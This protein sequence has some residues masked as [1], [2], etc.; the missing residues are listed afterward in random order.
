MLH[1]PYLQQLCKM[2]NKM[3]AKIT[4]IGSNLIN[5]TGVEYLGGC[6]HKILPDMI[7]I[8]SFIGLAAITKS[9]ITIKNVAY[10]ELGVIPSVF[11]K[12]GIKMERKRR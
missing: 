3:G 1:E 10:N 9:E 8:G 5:I 12:L 7:E 6:N 2:L 11:Q 4:G